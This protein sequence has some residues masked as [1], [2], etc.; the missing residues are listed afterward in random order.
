MKTVFYLASDLTP[1]STARSL[2]RI[3]AGLDRARFRVEV[4]A[5]QGADSPLADDLRAAGFP[6]HSLPIRNAL[7]WGGHRKVKR[8]VAAANPAILH[9]W[10]AAAVRTLPGFNAAKRIASEASFLPPGLAGRWASRQLRRCDRVVA[11]SWAEAERY[12]NLGV[13]GD[14]LT[15]IAPSVEPPKAPDRAALLKELQL[16]ANARIIVAAGRLEPGTGLKSAIWAFDLIRYEF[17]ELQL[18]IVGD[19]PERDSLHEFARALMFDDMRVRFIPARADLPQV[20]ALAEFAW[21]TNERGDAAL[22]LEAM[23]AGAVVIGWKLPQHV[24]AIEDGKSGL[25]VEL[26]DRA[27][28]AAKTYPLLTDAANR[29]ALGQAG[30]ERAATRYALRRAIEHFESLYEELG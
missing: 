15:R 25:L 24:E 30:R 18:V 3:A 2:A 14:R 16:P 21:V 6:V 17:P 10:G 7:D 8:A 12:R 27:Q 1:G 5:I 22:A 26:N 29:D 23:A 9:A 11:A 20:L 4:G 13:R 28:L 19:G